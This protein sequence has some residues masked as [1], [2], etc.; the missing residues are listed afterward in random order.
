MTPSSD[1]YQLQRFGFVNTTTFAGIKAAIDNAISKH[2]WVILTFHE[3]ASSSCGSATYCTTSA[4]FGQTS[5]YLAQ[6]HD[7]VVT[8]TQG[9]QS[10]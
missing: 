6:Q 8:L 5:D 1:P 10:F 7:P 4:I 2:E 3:V 9:I